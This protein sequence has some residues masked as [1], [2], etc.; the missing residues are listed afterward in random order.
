MRQRL[1]WVSVALLSACADDGG[2][3][4]GPDDIDFC[5]YFDC[6][7]TEDEE[8]GGGGGSAPDP[9]WDG[10]GGDAPPR[11]RDPDPEAPR[12]CCKYCNRSA[13]PCGDSCISAAR[14]CHITGGCACWE[15]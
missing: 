8:T 13:Q 11:P 10:W 4:P 5:L 14:E 7:S 15:P 9:D 3:P 12:G 2:T 6:E 1:V